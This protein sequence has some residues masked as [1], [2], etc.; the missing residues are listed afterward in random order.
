MWGRTTS[1]LPLISYSFTAGL[2]E[3]RRRGALSLLPLQRK[4][5]QV[6]LKV[7]GA[8]TV[9]LGLQQSNECN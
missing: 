3:Q 2:H 5:P 1:L 6:G 4:V 8:A 9:A 7:V